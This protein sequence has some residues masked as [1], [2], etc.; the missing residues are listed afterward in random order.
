MVSRFLK[1]GADTL[2]ARGMFYVVRFKVENRAMRVGH[3]WDNSIG[4]IVDERGNKYENISAVQ[5]FFEKSKPFGLKELYNTHAGTADSTYLA[6]DLPF[7][8]TKPWL[9]VRGEILM[10]DFFAGAKFKKAR[11]RLF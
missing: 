7:T 5:Q 8:V 1:N 11:I 3:R 9:K 2:H 6:F 4:Y 10:G